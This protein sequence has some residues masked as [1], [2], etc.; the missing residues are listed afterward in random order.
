M[1]ELTQEVLKSILSYDEATGIFRWKCRPSSRIVVGVVAGKVEGKGYI[2]ICYRR[3]RYKA[4]RL[5]WL[6]VH[7]INP[8]QEIDHINGVKTDN[9]IINLRSVSRRSNQQ[10]RAT[11]RLGRLPGAYFDG[12][13]KKWVAHIRINGRMSYIGRFSTEQ[14]SSNAYFQAVKELE[15]V[16]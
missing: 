4:H 8:P 14:E 11:H 9:R 15:G 5:A 10:N 1:K 13:R 7:G 3:E 12:R 2:E 6:Y 16:K